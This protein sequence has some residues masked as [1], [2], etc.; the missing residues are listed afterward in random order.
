MIGL[1]KGLLDAGVPVAYDTE[2]TDLLVED[3]RGVGVERPSEP[4]SAD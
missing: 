3:G 4:L 1:R 2:L